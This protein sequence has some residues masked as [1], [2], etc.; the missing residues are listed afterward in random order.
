MTTM[1][2]WSALALLALAGCGDE[3]QAADRAPPGAVADSGAAAA[4]LAPPPSGFQI[5]TPPQTIGPFEERTFCYYTTLSNPSAVGVK[6]YASQLMPGSHHMIMA[7]A[8]KALQPDGTIGDCGGGFG[9]IVFPAFGSQ[10][11]EEELAMPAGV[12]IALAARQAVVV[13]M[14]YLNPSDKPLTAGVTVNMETYAPG[15]TYT[16][17]APYATYNTRIA[18]PAQGTQTVHGSCDVPANVKFFSLSTHSH[19]YTTEAKAYDGANLL[20][21]TTSWEHPAVA[22]WVSAPITIASGKLDYECSYMN[23][24]DAPITVGES[25]LTN[26]MCMA[27]GYIFP[28]ATA[29]LCL[30]DAAFPLNR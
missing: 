25:A 12:G 13:Q 21:R 3:Q 17:A 7:Y 9:G 2:A 4:P 27:V 28:A 16:P 26:E 15:E 14:H 1:N 29:T 19:R 20:V 5:A 30:D 10:M 8:Q 23:P 11:R 22:N 24:T 6:R 18:V